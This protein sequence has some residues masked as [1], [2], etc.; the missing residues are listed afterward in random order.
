MPYHVSSLAQR[1]K[2]GAP[3]DETLPISNLSHL[4]L[5]YSDAIV[6]IPHEPYSRL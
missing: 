6:R 1:D 2:T 5:S 3:L 4:T